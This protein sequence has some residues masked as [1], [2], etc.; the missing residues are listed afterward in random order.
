M[1]NWLRDRLG[2]ITGSTG[3]FGS[4]ICS[5]LRENGA[6]FVELRQRIHNFS[7][8]PKVDYIIHL[9]PS[10]ETDRIIS[11]AKERDVPLLFTSSGAVYE[12]KGAYGKMKYENEL[13]FVESGIDVK[14]A[15]CFAFTGYGIPLNKG[16]ALGNFIRQARDGEDIRIHGTGTPIRTYMHMSDLVE[17][18]FKIL[19]DGE[20]GKP[21][22]VGGR[23]R[24]SI[25]GLARKVRRLM[26]VDCSI[27][28]ENRKD[29][30]PF[31]VPDLTDT[32]DL[33]CEI[34]VGLDEAI[35][36]TVEYYE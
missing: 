32:F 23:T 2:F 22:D 36:K 31:Y 13:K 19:I 26:G 11:L 14:I 8:P 35:R 21:Y 17:W 25:L 7:F 4:W 15:R 33:G 24:I 9:V 28:I 34:K 6:E 16:F 1:Y 18:L 3:W 27:Q 12:R 10:H 30:L 29:K 5:A 20:V